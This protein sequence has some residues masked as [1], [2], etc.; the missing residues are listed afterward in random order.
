MNE[1]LNALKGG[2][3]PEVPF[4]VTVD[5]DSIVKLA[6]AAVITAAIIILISKLVKSA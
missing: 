4:K 1:L 5:N 6:A 3:L 2:K